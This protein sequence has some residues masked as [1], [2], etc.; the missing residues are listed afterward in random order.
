MYDD[1]FSL[2]DLFAQ[3][4]RIMAKPIYATR[5]PHTLHPVAL[6]ERSP[7]AR[8]LHRKYRMLRYKF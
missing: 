8:N 2:A 3:A 7:S 4:D 5:K 6:I 1:N